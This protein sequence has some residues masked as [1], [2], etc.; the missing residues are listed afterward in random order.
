MIQTV[1]E[2][3]F[4]NYRN[5]KAR[6]IVYLSMSLYFKRKKEYAKKIKPK[7]KR[8]LENTSFRKTT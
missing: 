7:K 2:L 5:P 6:L 8:C 4:W 1:K 3:V